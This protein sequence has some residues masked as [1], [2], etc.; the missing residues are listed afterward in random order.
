MYEAPFD[1]QVG[2]CRARCGSLQPRWT[3]F[4]DRILHVGFAGRW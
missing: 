4:L 1:A 3:R 2:L